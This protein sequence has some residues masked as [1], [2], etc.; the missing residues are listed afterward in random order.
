MIRKLVLNSLLF[1]AFN[2]SFAQDLQLFPDPKLN[3]DSLRADSVKRTQTFPEYFRGYFQEFYQPSNLDQV[4]RI[5]KEYPDVFVREFRK[6][7]TLMMFGELI[8]TDT[9]VLSDSIRKK[10]RNFIL[11]ENYFGFRGGKLFRVEQLTYMQRENEI[12]NILISADRKAVLFYEETSGLN[13][14]KGENNLFYYY[15][16][17]LVAI[18]TSHSILTTETELSRFSTVKSL[19]KVV[20]IALELENEIKK[21]VN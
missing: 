10:M 21:S 17:A 19:P 2:C 11:G 16:G 7:S 4:I 3:L 12:H 6:V 14:I 8:S 18:G 9:L 15:E 5:K 1:I 13:S 20:V